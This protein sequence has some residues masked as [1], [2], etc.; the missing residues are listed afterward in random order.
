MFAENLFEGPIR[1]ESIRREP[2]D[3]RFF[4]R[5]GDSHDVDYP[6]L[7]PNELVQVCYVAFIQMC[8]VLV[9]QST[10]HNRVVY[11]FDICVYRKKVVFGF[12]M[13]C[14]RQFHKIIAPPALTV[15]GN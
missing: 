5:L 3:P 8:R 4:V 1:V 2:K 9:R 14:M 12:Y 11:I 7:Q 6:E 13:C 15:C 10:E